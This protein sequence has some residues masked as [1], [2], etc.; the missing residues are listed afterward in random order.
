MSSDTRFTFHIEEMGPVLLG[1]VV[2]ELDLL[3]EPDLVSAFIQAVESSAATTSVLDMR[4]VGFMDSSGLR[5]VLVCR[6][7]AVRRG[8]TFSLAVDGGPVRRF[9]DVAGVSDWFTY[10]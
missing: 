2:G 8:L 9:L 1:T 5:G 4:H 3:T 10:V 7:R 6:D